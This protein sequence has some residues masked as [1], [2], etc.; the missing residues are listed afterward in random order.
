MHLFRAKSRGRR[1]AFTLIELLV[2]ITIIA[3][4]VAILLPALAQSRESARKIQCASQTR[5]V[6]LAFRTYAHDNQEWLPATFWGYSHVLTAYVAPLVQPPV[7]PMAWGGWMTS[8]LPDVRILRCTSHDPLL[9]SDGG[10]PFYTPQYAHNTYW[11]TYFFV[12]ATG[13]KPPT[14]PAGQVAGRVVYAN[15]TPTSGG[16]PCPRL[17]YANSTYDT[18]YYTLYF[19]KESE[20]P[21]ATDMN[22]PDLGYW[23][24][25]GDDRHIRNNHADGQNTVYL[26]GH[27]QFK[28]NEDITPRYADFANYAW[29]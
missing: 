14:P 8:Y 27:V 11:A 10:W 15:S 12:S 13:D 29:W 23:I 19:A 21:L 7:S 28:R 16:A 20:Q 17:T 3:L 4:M 2:V 25:Y 26:D 1:L 22:R 24:S 6:H 9:T 18:G 5:Q